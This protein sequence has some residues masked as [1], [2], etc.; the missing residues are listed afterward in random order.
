LT[1]IPVVINPTAGDGRLLRRRHELAQAARD[2]GVELEWWLTERPGQGAQLARRAAADG[3]PLVLAWGGDGTYNEVARGLLGSATAMGV[4]PGGST[5]VLAYELA[6]PRP[7]AKAL[8][9]LLHGAD[10]PMRVGH[11]DHDDVVLLMLSAGVDALVVEEAFR[12]RRR[13]TGKIG[14]A[15]QAVRELARR[16]PLPRLRVRTEGGTIE[17]GWVIVGNARCYA[18]PFRATPAADPFEPG[19][20]VVVHTAVGRPPAVG[21]AL[22]LAL[23]RHLRRPDVLRKRCER[24]IVEPAAGSDRLPYQVDGDPIMALPVTLEVDPRP[25]LVRLPATT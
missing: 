10:R 3:S 11:S 6:V 20:E 22:T 25:L 24:V 5:S 23:G 16:R 1:L 21:F 12:R 7:E 14:I 4:L 19:F 17:G 13:N 9:S 2:C 8:V 15:L 18:G